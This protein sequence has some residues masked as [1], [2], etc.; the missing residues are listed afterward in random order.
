MRLQGKRCLVTGASGGIG[1]ATAK[2]MAREGARVAVHYS[3]NKAKAEGVVEACRKL[4][5]EAFAVQADVAERA[6]CEAMVGEVVQRWGG[7]DALACFAGDPWRAADWFAPFEEQRDE[8][9][10]A[11][12]RIDLLGTVHCA[13][14][15]I[16]AMRRQKG[17]AMLF[18]SSVPG[19][20]GDVEGFSYLPAKAGI[21][22]LAKSLARTLGKDHIRVNALALGSV[23]T[24]AMKGL[25]PEQE[26]ALA[27]E[28]ALG[29]LAE[30]EEVARAAVF[31]LSD[32]ASFLTGT[33]VPLDGGLTYH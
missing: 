3:G 31:L 27:S 8:A 11:A 4:G 2:A 10:E 12:F 17:G 9:F 25:T 5:A 22:V 18:T 30:P 14:A 6:A 32:D 29:R 13:Q 1:A 21:A 26:R 28:S 23:R 16:P 33:A 7:L 19:L 24:E 20:V 15:A